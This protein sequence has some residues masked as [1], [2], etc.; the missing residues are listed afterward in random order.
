MVYVLTYQKI[1]FKA[2][3]YKGLWQT[4][5]RRCGKDIFGAINRRQR[6][7]LISIV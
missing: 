7:K 6:K 4:L 3:F 1:E 5:K 2:K